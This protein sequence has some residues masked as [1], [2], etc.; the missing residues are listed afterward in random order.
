MAM[1]ALRSE[2]LDQGDLQI[3]RLYVSSYEPRWLGDMPLKS[4]T[5]PMT[6]EAALNF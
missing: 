1:S 2:P 6:F 5:C 3:T 4:C